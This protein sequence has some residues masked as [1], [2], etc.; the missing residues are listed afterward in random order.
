MF[1]LEKKKEKVR[2]EFKEL[3]KGQVYEDKTI[4]YSNHPSSERDF[5]K[6]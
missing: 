6:S 1:E 2:N 4:K 5:P 3:Q